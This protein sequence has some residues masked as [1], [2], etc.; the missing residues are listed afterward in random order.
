MPELSA[1]YATLTA[2]SLPAP[3]IWLLFTLAG[4]TFA[5]GGSGIAVRVAEDRARRP[6]PV[7]F[8][9]DREWLAF[10]ATRD[11]AVAS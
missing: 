2:V 10:A 9:V 7:V 5:W 3:V 6:V 4:L 11:M 1:L 8:L